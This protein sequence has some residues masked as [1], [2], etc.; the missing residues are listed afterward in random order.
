[1]RLL[2]II[3]FFSF[4]SVAADWPQVGAFAP[5]IKL[6]DTDGKMFVLGEQKNKTVL[7]FYRG[8][9]CPY[10]IRQ[11]KSIKEDLVKKA[12]QKNVKLVAISV[13]KLL[14]AKKMK[15]KFGFDFT[16]ISDPKAE[17]LKA[18]KI[19]NKLSDELVRKY[20]NSYQIDVE[21][22]SGQIHHMVAHPAV[23]IV[24]NKKVIFSDVHTDYKQRTDNKEILKALGID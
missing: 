22:D 21:N 24:E 23:F 15:K 12:K 19:V 1:M 20:K 2:L 14:V 16:I 7:V 3:L 13:D 11:L 17:S 10:C 4:T 6:K 5:E 18:Y 9:W 8:S